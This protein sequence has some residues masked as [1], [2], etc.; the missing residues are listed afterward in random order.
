MA[1]LLTGATGF[2]GQ[3]VVKLKREFRC[4]VRLGETHSFM[5]SYEISGIDEFTEWSDCFHGVDSVI[6]LAGLAHNKSF[7]EAE[8]RC[9]NTNGTLRLAK[10]AAEAGVRRF[11]FVSSIGVNGTSTVE[12]PFTPHS[13]ENPHNLYAQSKYHAELGLKKIS[14]DTGL[15]V[16]IVRPTLVYGANAPG[17]FGLLTN[18]VSKF[19]IL[20]FGLAHN[21]RDFIAV[22]NL[23][24]LLIT[25]ATHPAAAGHTFLASDGETVSTKHFTNAIA[26][27]LGKKVIQLPIPVSFMRFVGKLV[28][29]STMI[30]QLYGDLEVDS[31]NI[32]EVL[33]WTPPLTMKQAMDTLRDF[34]EK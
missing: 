25:C 23:V 20:P 5:D 24:D 28:G 30:E 8:Y 13:K 4:V 1:I 33:D 18:L 19:S 22:Q 21:R 12:A 17:N 26:E 32:T 10:K 6:H 14:E 2:V 11:V 31:S 27:G 29:K 7:S 3:E 16:V 15:E 9:V 34:R